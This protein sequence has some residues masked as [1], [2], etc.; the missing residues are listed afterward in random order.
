LKKD[1]YYATG[2]FAAKAH[3]TKKTLRYYDEHGFLKPSF[4]GESGARFYTDRDFE[5]MQRILLL[6]Y[7]G[8]SL[9]D[10]RNTEPEQDTLM[11]SLK[12][13]LGLLEERLK[14]MTLVRDIL[15]NTMDE[16]GK[17]GEADWSELMKLVSEESLRKSLMQQYLDTSN[18]SARIKLHS[19]YSQN[20]ESWFPWIFKHC[21]IENAGTVLEIGCG[22]GEFWIQ[23]RESIPGKLKVI[24][25]DSSE[26]VLREVAKKLGEDKRFS[27]RAMDMACLEVPDHT[28]DIVIANHVLFYAEDI[29]KVLKEIKRVLKKDGRLVCSTYGEKHMHE[30]GDMMKRFDDRIV[31]AAENLY[32]LFGKTNGKEILSP[33][34]SGVE[35]I[36]YED[37]LFVTKE[38]DL[39]DYIKSC[40][41]NQNRYIV[42]KYREFRTFVHE[43]MGRGL[44]VTKEAGIFLCK[45]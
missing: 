31:L 24:L 39:I 11:S 3:V 34:F 41:G 14:Q 13:Q 18:I 40:H 12:L 44:H 1:G 33:F 22:N 27:L 37:S 16:V 42:D 7:L 4:V 9:E 17:K 8:L 25:S 5:K 20:K 45:V 19:L 2:E 10:I 38:E 32:E 15:I 36:E 21:G 23:N 6:K 35:W 28:A 29:P 43:E 30:I 26:G